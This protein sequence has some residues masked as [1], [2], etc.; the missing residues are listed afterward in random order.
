M[1]EDEEADCPNNAR[2]FRIAVS[3]NLKNIAESVSEN[4]FLEILTILKSNPKTAQKLHKAMIKELYNSMDDDLKDI[5]KEGS[6]QETL[7][8]IAKLSEESTTSANE[9]AWRPPGDVTRHMRSLD[10][11]K[12]KE[13]TEELEERVS[14]MERENKILMRTIAECRSRIRTTNDNVTRILNSAPIILQ[15]LENTREQLTTCLKTIENE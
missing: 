6:L 13:A 12:I 2:L 14:E 10:A 5:L 1:A 3:N 11:H 7:T 4:E 15:R 9:H 8:K